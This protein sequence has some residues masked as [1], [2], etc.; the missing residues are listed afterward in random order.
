M[1]KLAAT[2]VFCDKPEY[3]KPI[4]GES[5]KLIEDSGLKYT[6]LLNTIKWAKCRELEYEIHNFTS[7]LLKPRP[8]ICKEGDARIAYEAKQLAEYEKA[9]ENP[10]YI[11]IIRKA[12]QSILNT[13]NT[14]DLQTEQE[15]LPLETKMWFNNRYVNS[16]KC[17]HRYFSEIAQE[18]S[19]DKEQLYICDIKTQPL[20]N[21]IRCALP[22]IVD[23]AIAA[24][25]NCEGFYYHYS[26]DR[27]DIRKDAHR[28][29]NIGVHYNKPTRLTFIWRYINSL[30]HSSEMTFILNDGDIYFLTD[31]ISNGTTYHLA[32]GE[33]KY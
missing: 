23:D 32:Y 8:T 4:E 3:S 1:T 33:E 16:K 22:V 18:A 5:Y 24:N 27:V 29:L 14:S 15:K 11:L 19:A 31:N 26:T 28:R 20:L 10:V 17:S 13:E 9:L 25:L 21:T 12:V 2:L 6:H 7:L 30:R